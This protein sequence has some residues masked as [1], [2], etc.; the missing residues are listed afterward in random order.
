VGNNDN[1]VYALGWGPSITFTLY[2]A[3][4]APP[5]ENWVSIPFPD[6]G[7]DTLQDLGESIAAAFTPSSG[8]S[9][10]TQLHDAGIPCTYEVTGLY[11]GVTWSWGGDTT[12][13]IPIGAMCKVFIDT[14][15]DP[16][17]WTIT[18]SCAYAVQFTLYDLSGDDDNENWISVPWSKWYLPTTENIVESIGYSY[19]AQNNDTLTIRCLD[20]EEEEEYEIVSTYRSATMQWSWTAG[21]PHDVS[22]GTPLKVYPYRSGGLTITWP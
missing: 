1:N 6:T 18:G 13:P 2:G 11:N 9:V 4:V 5:W 22:A 20:A 15:A 7:I 17:E 19:G 16:F 3:D 10:V 12:E 14:A 8:D 21:A